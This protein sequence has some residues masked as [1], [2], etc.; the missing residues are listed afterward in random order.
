MRESIVPSTMN[1]KILRE[2]RNECLSH[3]ENCLRRHDDVGFKL[4]KSHYDAIIED[5]E[6]VYKYIEDY[7]AAGRSNSQL[8]HNST[9]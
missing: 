5:M 3:M 9:N 2:E 6:R 7:Y 4:W 8:T 1:Y